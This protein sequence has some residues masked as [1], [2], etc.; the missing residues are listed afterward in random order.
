M[1]YLCKEENHIADYALPDFITAGKPDTLVLTECVMTMSM[2][3]MTDEEVIAAYSE[4]VYNLAAARTNQPSDADDVYQEVFYQYISKSPN[5][6]SESHARAWFIT[7]T[8][9]LTKNIYKAFEVSKRADLDDDLMESALSDEGFMEEVERRSDYEKNIRQ[10]LPQYKTV[11]CLYFDCG[12]T[13]KEIGRFLKKSEGNVKVLLMRAK[14]QYRRIF[15][16]SMEGDDKN[17]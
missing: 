15:L 17:A 2:K 7:V 3:K 13:I 14:R 5:F 6:Q 12:Y 9:N 16:D 11:L 4:L 10:L 8:L 1:Y